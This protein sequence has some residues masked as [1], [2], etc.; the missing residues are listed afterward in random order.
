MY[1]FM[2]TD[3]GKVFKCSIDLIVLWALWRQD[4]RLISRQIN[5]FANADWCL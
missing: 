2:S 5:G 4:I 3:N 1:V